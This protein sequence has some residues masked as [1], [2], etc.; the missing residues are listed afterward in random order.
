MAY[1]KILPIKRTLNK[2]I[3]YIIDPAKTDNQLLV[4]GFNC[5]PLTASNE[6]ECTVALAKMVTD[7]DTKE[8]TVIARHIIQSF[9][10]E[11]NV[12]ENKAHEI[13]KKLADELL[14]GRFEYVIATHN[15]K[16]HI[17]NHIIFNAV[18]FV[19]YKKFQVA[20]YKTVAKLRALS[21]RLCIENDLS[22]I[23]ENQNLGYS[24]F[25]YLK[26]QEYNKVRKEIRQR[27]KF[28]LDR[29]SNMEDFKK[30][31][32]SLGVEIIEKDNDFIYRLADTSVP[33]AK[34][35]KDGEVSKG[36]IEDI[37]VTNKGEQE[38]IKE[39]IQLGVFKSESYEQFIENLKILNIS[40][41]KIKGRNYFIFGDNVRVAEE[42]I[43][44][45]YSVDEI[46]RR[47]NA[48]DLNFEIAKSFDFKEEFE[49]KVKASVNESLVKVELEDKN[50]VQR[51]KNGLLIEV[52]INGLEQRIFIPAG[53]VQYSPVRNKYDIYLGSRF[54]YYY[55]DRSG[56]SVKQKSVKGRH[57]IRNI[58][59]LNGR[60]P[61]M[62]SV[63]NSAILNISKKGVM[64]S[65][66][67]YGIQKMFIPS[68]FVEIDRTG[69]ILNVAL[70]K[71][72]YYTYTQVSDQNKTIKKNIPGIELAEAIQNVS[73]NSD[74][75]ISRRLRYLDRYN[76]FEKTKDL[77]RTLRYI[78][79]EN[80]KSRAD[81]YKR[82]DSFDILSVSIDEKLKV[83]DNK[84]YD[85]ESA[86][87]YLQTY[88]EYKVYHDELEKQGFFT[89]NKYKEAHSLDLRV[90]EGSIENL[91]SVNIDPST[92]IADMKSLIMNTKSER[93]SIKFE[94]DNTR[95]KWAETN[96]IIDIVN[97]IGTRGLESQR[98][99]Q[100]SISHDMDR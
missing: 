99:V 33:A 34:L 61:E 39:E 98:Y 41:E 94:Y 63:P 14:E 76:A 26:S 49:T 96:K 36:S 47:I 29:T 100:R 55:S 38:Y 50:I 24:Y 80:I 43:G 75:S 30:G 87:G 92:N 85:Y 52:P 81:I 60:K 7:K 74:L 40:F 57:L 77:A 70:Y 6:F 9:S 84:I 37:L 71:N 32:A 68:E 72:W 21:D 23:K 58:D 62:V 90:F 95:R 13:G 91:Q 69:S 64:I 1:A 83:I 48:R 45:E 59:L 20:P 8:G 44:S 11:D 5:E 82:R 78:N 4:T 12:D 35:S 46:K 65:L 51:S 93:D 31:L 56:E 16:G 89:K 25:Q 67:D 18:S 53:N 28:V 27:I 88:N 19:D 86:L 22:V 15:D 42:I 66:L 79:R 3:N 10:P 54:D 97:D 17:H 2:S 73:H